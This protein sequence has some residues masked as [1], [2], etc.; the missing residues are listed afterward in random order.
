MKGL[1]PLDLSFISILKMEAK[2]ILKSVLVIT[3]VI[4][5][6][7][8]SALILSALLENSSFTSIVKSGSVNNETGG[9]INSSGYTLEQASR[10]DF[11]IVNVEVLNTSDAIVIDSGNYTITDG[12]MTNATETVWTDVET[13]YNYTYT[14][15][16]NLAGVNVATLE[17]AFSGF[18]TGLIGFFAVIGVILAIIWLISYIK[19]LF[20]KKDGI[21][22]FAGN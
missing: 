9:F 18:V 5:L 3:S 16:S 14:D 2:E 12:V 10:T 19:P 22:S 21:Q 15:G 11:T 1:F 6:V 4:I 17:A 13:S 8:V 7:L 20:S